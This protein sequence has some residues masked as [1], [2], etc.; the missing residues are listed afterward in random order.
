M[1][2]LW[3][4]L[5]LAT[6]YYEADPHLVVLTSE[7]TTGELRLR[8]KR[9]YD[10]LRPGPITRRHPD[11]LVVARGE[12]L[13]LDA[14]AADDP[15]AVVARYGLQGRFRRGDTPWDSYAL[16]LVEAAL[17][18]LTPA[19]L[20]VVQ[21]LDFVRTHVASA[22]LSQRLGLPAERIGAALRS[23]E[24][25]VYVELY[26]VALAVPVLFV[27]DV[28]TPMPLA[29]RSV[30]HELGHAV[31]AHPRQEQW[32][33]LAEVRAALQEMMPRWDA[34]LAE[35]TAHNQRRRPDAAERARLEAQEA[36]LHAEHDALR[37]EETRLG[38]ALPASSGQLSP[39]ARQLVALLGDTPA[40]T[41]YGRTSG[42]PAR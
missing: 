20:V 22:E 17:A 33:A 28:R 31:S 27:G 34:H 9:L 4:G 14:I 36:A 41:R 16:G 5:A 19:E 40:P 8:V 39:A 24:D 35:A 12:A 2:G 13:V 10:R 7:P 30:L 23:G 18:R 11:R 15:A 29:L 38:R 6:P 42:W 37:A 26:D 3:L 1:I 21:H 25:G 32:R